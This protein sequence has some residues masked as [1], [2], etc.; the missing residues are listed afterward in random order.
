MDILLAH[1]LVAN[2]YSI[3]DPGVAIDF[4]IMTFAK[5]GNR[6]AIPGW[7]SM[8]YSSTVMMNKIA[9]ANNNMK[10]YAVHVII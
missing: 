10:F 2:V 9:R 8:L 5:T 4:Q 6:V 1:E 7:N 3:E